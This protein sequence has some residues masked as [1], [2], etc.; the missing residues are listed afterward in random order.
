MN[1]T[2]CYE[3]NPNHRGGLHSYS[4]GVVTHALCDRHAEELG[5]KQAETA[6]ELLARLGY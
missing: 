3:L 2:Q 1:E 4:D 6:E 5:F